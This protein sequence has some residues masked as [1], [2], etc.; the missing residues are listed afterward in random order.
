MAAAVNNVRSINYSYYTSRQIYDESNGQRGVL[1]CLLNV[2]VYNF[3]LT[4]IRQYSLIAL[5][6]HE[7]VAHKKE[8]TG[9]EQNGTSF[10]PLNLPSPISLSGEIRSK[11]KE[12]SL[13]PI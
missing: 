1:R 7:N 6:Y 9:L 3:L 4:L 12:S 11:L 13:L 8:K 2:I 10:D 5:Q